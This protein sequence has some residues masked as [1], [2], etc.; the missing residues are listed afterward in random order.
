M[1]AELGTSYPLLRIQLLGVNLMGHESGNSLIVAGRTIPMLQDRDSDQ[2]GQSDAWT[3]WATEWRDVVIL[4]GQNVKTGVFNLTQHNLAT[5]SE[6]ETLKT[7]LIDA[8]MTNQKPWTN[9]ALG[10]DTDV[11]GIVAPKDALVIINT[12]N[13]DGSRKMPPPTGNVLPAFR[14]DVNGDG[15]VAPGDVLQVINYINSHGNA[16]EGEA[17]VASSELPFVQL[18]AAPIV[19]TV[20]LPLNAVPTEHAVQVKP[21]SRYPSPL[22][23]SVIVSDTGSK[24]FEQIDRLWQEHAEN[25]LLE[26]GML[27]VDLSETLSSDRPTL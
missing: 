11:D 23:E 2:D 24:Q 5:A 4:D 6:Y 8:A 17:N 25:S 19:S 16:G 15:F 9:R 18:A 27:G 3:A 26:E 13:A 20:T 22:N 7:M 10:V 1:Q 12:I 14:Y 21:I